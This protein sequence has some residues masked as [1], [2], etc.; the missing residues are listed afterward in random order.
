MFRGRG[1]VIHIESPSD[2]FFGMG[3]WING[4][5]KLDNSDV[6][7]LKSVDVKLKGICDLYVSKQAAQ[8]RNHKPKDVKKENGVWHEKDFFLELVENIFPRGDNSPAI[9]NGAN[10]FPF[11]LKIPA[12]CVSSKQSNW[13]GRPL[14]P[15]TTLF[16]GRGQVRYELKAVV[17]KKALLNRKS[18]STLV[19][20]IHTTPAVDIAGSEY[21]QTAFDVPVYGAKPKKVLA[22]IQSVVGKTKPKDVWYYHSK[23]TVRSS[24]LSQNLAEVISLYIESTQAEGPVILDSFQVDII[25]TTNVRARGISE[26]TRNLITLLHASGMGR[27][28]RSQNQSDLFKPAVIPNNLPVTQNSASYTIFHEIKVILGVKP[29]S[30]GDIK[31]KRIEMVCKLHVS[32]SDSFDAIT[33]HDNSHQELTRDSSVPGDKGY[34]DKGVL[35]P[36]YN[37]ATSVPALDS[38][39]I[40]P[41]NSNH[42]K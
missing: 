4:T 38:P 18:V 42:L 30:G 8:E 29:S 35:P 40:S 20:E 26:E 28:V 32:F 31:A 36:S 11:S 27:I 21:A 25:T 19:L 2:G 9:R 33:A 12:A 5:V 37:S 10:E 39:Y 23:I 3:K 22:K 7:A 14:P 6:S 16:W 1:P 13:T 41:S 15:S 17:T 24:K 34:D